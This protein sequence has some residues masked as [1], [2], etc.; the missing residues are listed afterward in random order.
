VR[1]PALGVQSGVHGPANREGIAEHAQAVSHDVDFALGGID[2]FHGKIGDFESKSLGQ[3]EHF[4]VECKAIQLLPRKNLAAR[5]PA[6]GLEPA[7]GIV[8]RR[9]PAS[10]QD[11]IER[12]PHRPP[13]PRLAPRDPAQGV[14]AIADEDIDPR[15][16][17][18][19]TQE[20]GHL[21]ERHTEIRTI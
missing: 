3:E 4:H 14:P 9:E 13:Q 17:F 8:Q 16:L 19:M 15:I 11:P 6:K 7:L 5:L 2:P 10:L 21:G 18:P 1:G 20:G 12:L